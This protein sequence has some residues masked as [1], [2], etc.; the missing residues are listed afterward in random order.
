MEWWNDCIFANTFYQTRTRMK[1]WLFLATL[2][3]TAHSDLDAERRW[4]LRKCIDYAMEH[5]ITPRTMTGIFV[6]WHPA[7]KAANLNPIEAIRYE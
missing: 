7:K 6:G 2:L 1:K 4:S 5:N 3:L